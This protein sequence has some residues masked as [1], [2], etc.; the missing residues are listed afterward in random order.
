MNIPT[1]I[2]GC[3]VSKADISIDTYLSFRKYGAVPKPIII[4]NELKIELGKMHNRRN[5]QYAS[6]KEKD[7][8]LLKLGT[9]PLDVITI[10]LDEITDIQICFVMVDY[11]LQYS[12]TI[13]YFDDDFDDVF[14]IRDNNYD[15]ATGQP[16][17]PWNFTDDEDDFIV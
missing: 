8:E 11:N 12:M 10:Y 3:I 4:P 15:Y 17:A 14:D 2:I 1:D 5:A 9:Y 16:C 7:T 13:S 6:L